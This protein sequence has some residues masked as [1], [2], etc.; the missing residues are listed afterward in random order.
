MFSYNSLSLSLYMY[1]Y[2]HI[3]THIYIHITHSKRYEV[4][5]RVRKTKMRAIQDA[6]V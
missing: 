1:I 3:Y 5:A 2:T 6:G 4:A